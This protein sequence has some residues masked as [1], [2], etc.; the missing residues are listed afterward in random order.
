MMEVH[1]DFAAMRFPLKEIMVSS[2]HRKLVHYETSGWPALPGHWR[3]YVRARER[4]WEVVDES[5][6]LDDLLVDAVTD[7][8]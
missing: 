6:V 5:D 8:A 2:S 1:R 3:E 7:T 4:F